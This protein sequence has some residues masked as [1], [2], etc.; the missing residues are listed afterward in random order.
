MVTP[1]STHAL[2]TVMHL[3]KTKV[4]QMITPWLETALFGTILKKTT[5]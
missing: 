5:N 2:S 4:W 3:I 1:L